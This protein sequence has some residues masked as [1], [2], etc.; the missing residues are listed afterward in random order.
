MGELFITAGAVLLLFCVYQLWWT[1]VEA[2]RASDSALDGLSRLWQSGQGPDVDDKAKPQAPI[3][4]DAWAILRIPRLGSDWEEPVLE[5]VGGDELNKG[6]GHYPES[7]R[8]GR[9]GNVALAGHRATNGEPFRDLDRM[10]PGDTIVLETRDSIY[11]Y[12]VDDP[13]RI[14]DPTQVGVVLPVPDQPEAKPTRQIVTLT[15][16]NPRWASTERLIVHGVLE[17]VRPR[18]AAS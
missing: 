2:A 3:P 8:P 9:N 7:G 12:V 11:T 1:N 17:S 13:W 15:T 5:G 16:C 6:I 4:G 18:A 14:V 10:R